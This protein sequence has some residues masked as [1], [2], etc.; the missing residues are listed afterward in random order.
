LKVHSGWV[1][2]IRSLGR[3]ILAEEWEAEEWEA[4]EW[5]AEELRAEEWEAEELREGELGQGVGGGLVGVFRLT[6]GASGGNVF[7]SVVSG[8]RKGRKG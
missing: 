7:G 3:G 5:E 8:R 1:E 6:C 2:I 4:E